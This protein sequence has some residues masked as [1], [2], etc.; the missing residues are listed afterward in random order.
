MSLY[1]P[2]FE[3]RNNILEYMKN[4][5]SKIEGS[6]NYDIASAVSFEMEQSYADVDDLASELVPW[7]VSREPYLTFHMLSFG[8]ERISDTKAVGTINVEGS[9]FSTLPIGA[10][11]VSRLSQRYATTS[12]LILDAYG[13]GS[14]GIEAVVGGFKGNCGIGDING[15]EIVLSNIDKVYNAEPIT[16]GADIETVESCIARMKEKASVPAHSGNKNNYKIWVKETGGVGK[17]A[18]VGAG[19]GSV[20][21]GSVWI[22]FSTSTGDVPSEQQVAD[23]QEY[24]NNEDRIPVCANVKVYPFEPLITNFHFDSITVS[25]GSITEE[26]FI[27]KFKSDVKIAY[28]TDGFILSNLVPLSKI[29]ALVFGITGVVL[30]DNLKINGSTSN[31]PLAF[32]QTPIV[33]EVVIDSFVEV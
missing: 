1:K 6:Y 12:T 17:V 5:L 22:Y 26:E 30:Y 20:P 23:V 21:P 24:L 3:I 13:K 18:V 16:G 31:I 2:H 8:L 10:I 29:S 14:V 33:G 27:A 25:K 11:V 19:E 28:A 4:S 15:V 7:T 32:N 9:P